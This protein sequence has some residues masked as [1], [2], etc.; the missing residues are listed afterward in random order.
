[1][2]VFAGTTNLTGALDIKVTKA[3][4]D[5]T[6]GKV[7]HLIIEAEKTQLPIMRIIDS[8]IKWYV[9]TMLMIAAIIWFFTGD[10]KVQS[11]EVINYNSDGRYP[12]DHMPVIAEF[13]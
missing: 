5:T 9:P 2:Q 3:G 7:Q 4:E 12:S 8:H 10:I 6:L 1:M 13:K 11:S